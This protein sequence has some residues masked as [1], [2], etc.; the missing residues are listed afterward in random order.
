MTNA[1]VSL[2]PYLESLLLITAI[3]AGSL[4]GLFTTFETSL[5]DFFILVMLFFLFYNISLS[6]LFNG[7][8]NGKYLSMALLS[9]FIALPIIAFLLSRLFVEPS[10]AIFVGLMVYLVAPCTDWF[11]G[12]TQL[13][14][15]D[16]EVNSALLPIN[17]IMQILLLPVYLYVFTANTI[18]IPT[19]AF[20]DVMV[21]WVLIPFAVAQLVRL[22]VSKIS[23]ALLARSN[24]LI[25][26]LVLVAMVLLVFSIF[27]THIESLINHGQILPRVFMVI[28]TFFV[29]AFFFAR[30]ISRIATFSKKE[31]ISLT[32]TTAAR[33]AP[34][35]L[36]ISLLFFPDVP[37]IHVVLVVGMLI[38]F[39]HLITITYI[40]KKST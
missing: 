11:L 34:L 20:M 16:V 24:V 3:V 38:E 10:H 30:F 33:N 18:S 5:T 22:I 4:T 19:D 29:A 28:L 14:H 7:I 15:G 32:M 40:L 37:L 36:V 1:S 2:K 26:W 39:P 9:N 25:E 12:F 13:A 23:S 35:M 17:L 27:N 31:E 21:Y 6:G 8:R